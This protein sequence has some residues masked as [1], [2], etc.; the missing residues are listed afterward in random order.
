MDTRGFILVAT[1]CALVLASTSIHS[2]DA[3][4]LSALSQQETADQLLGIPENADFKELNRETRRA[5]YKR[6][7]GMFIIKRGG[8]Y[9]IKK[10][11]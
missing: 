2:T 7:A 9:I 10:M 3:A 4:S 1:L 5:S 6:R 11:F 8:A